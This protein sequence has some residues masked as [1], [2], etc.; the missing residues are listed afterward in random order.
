MPRNNADFQFSALYHGSEHPFA[1]GD[2]VEPNKHMFGKAYAT[3]HAHVA[4]MFGRGH[5]YQVEPIGDH[6]VEFADTESPFI[7]SKQG[8]KV[9]KKVQEGRD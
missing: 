6:E 4:S 9:I 1:P 3:P 7:T 8:F 2:V 5:V